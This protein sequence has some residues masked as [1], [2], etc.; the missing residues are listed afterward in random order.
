MIKSRFKIHSTPKI[1]GG[2]KGTGSELF[3]L[4]SSDGKFYMISRSGRIEKVVDAHK[5]ATLTAKWSHDGSSL[6]TTGE[7]GAV[8]IWSR[9]GM[10]RSTLSQNGKIKAWEFVP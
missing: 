3:V 1:S 4:T 5:G 8:K 10:L 6:L 9:A 7:D 2:K